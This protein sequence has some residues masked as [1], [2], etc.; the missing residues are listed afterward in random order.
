MG[1]D[2]VS[3][4]LAMIQAADPARARD[5][6][7]GRWVYE[8]NRAAIDKCIKEMFQT[9][10]EQRCMLVLP[11]GGEWFGAVVGSSVMSCRNRTGPRA[12]FYDLDALHGVT[13]ERQAVDDLAD[14]FAGYHGDNT[15]CK[16]TTR[17]SHGIGR[18]LRVTKA[19][20]QG[21][22]SA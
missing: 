6:S 2:R 14:H 7:T 9:K 21:L 4:G 19:P 12:G 1:N 18:D 8:T 13:V 11:G 20:G 22:L 16:A 15:F 3:A 17:V 5:I 10:K